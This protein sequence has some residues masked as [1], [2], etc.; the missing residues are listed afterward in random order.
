M[1]KPLVK[2]SSNKLSEIMLP[3]SP[4]ETFVCVLSSMNLLHYDDWKDTDAVQILFIFLDT[5]NEEFVRKGSK[6]PFIE[7]AVRFAGRHKAL[8]LGVLGWASYLQKNM[9]AF[10]SRKAAQLNYEIFEFLD[11]E[12]KAASAKLAEWFDESPVTRGTGYRNATRMATAPTK[13]SSAC[14]GQVSP[15]IEP[16]WSN[17]YIYDL[18]KAKFTFKNPYLEALLEEKG[19]NT[20]AVWKQIA[21]AD[22]SVQRLD[23]LTSEEKE[24]FKT[25]AEIRTETIIDQAATRQDFIDQGQSL[26]VLIDPSL[27]V[28]EINALV[29]RA[30]KLG[31][32]SLYYQHSI[33]A[34]QAAARNMNCSSCEG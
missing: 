15:S 22:G 33:N 20:R 18:A 26:N 8:G 21:D 32:K 24:V 10:E 31:V 19:M 12:T 17:F 23:G 4:E 2:A 6:I 1:T 29:F 25:F 13:S 7:R 14:L 34:A 3:S 16:Y 28:K 5:V 9:I 11:K 30:W 27:P